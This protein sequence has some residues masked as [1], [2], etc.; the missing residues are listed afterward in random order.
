ME[1]P[2]D[3]R[4]ELPRPPGG[5]LVEVSS[6]EMEKFLLKRL[7]EADND[8]TQALWQLAQFYKQTRQ[9]EKAVTRLHQLLEWLPG[10]EDL[11]KCHLSMGQVMEQA[12][13]YAA[14]A[15]H[16]REAMALEPMHT[17]TWYFVNNNLGF[18]LV[19]LD[20]CA[21]AENYCRK[22]VETDPNR[23]NAY[24]NLGAALSGQ[25][26][27]REA[28]QCFIA[29]TQVNAADDSA[30]VLLQGLLREH[31]ELEFDF[32]SA[33]ACCQKAVEAAARKMEEL[34]PVVHR[35]WSKQL[36]LFR[37]KVRAL[38]RRLWTGTQ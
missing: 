8:P 20:R 6:S 31:P 18:C 17:S 24:K 34:K 30:F 23:P 15:G 22:A 10:A 25:G 21:E 1:T 4:F 14:A 36:I 11:A 19:T 2:L 13:L 3:F 5:P 7:E 38:I 33:A 16:Y 29:A 9:P 12:R 27:Y 28:A 37:A 26:R 32:G 35:G